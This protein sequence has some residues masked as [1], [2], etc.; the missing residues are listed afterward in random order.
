M[1]FSRVEIG[2]QLR[3]WAGPRYS[4]PLF[5]VPQSAGT[6][7]PSVSHCEIRKDDIIYGRLHG[8]FSGPS[9][10]ADVFVEAIHREA[11]YI[12]E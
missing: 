7:I 2:M 12:K 5:A 6:L 10:E 9:E 11:H 3:G 4:S 8:H 1:G